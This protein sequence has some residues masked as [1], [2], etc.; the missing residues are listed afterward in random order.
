VQTSE[1]SSRIS[2]L[3]HENLLMLAGLLDCF[4]ASPQRFVLELS[5]LDCTVI[6]CAGVGDTQLRHLAPVPTSMGTLST[7]SYRL[8]KLSGTSGNSGRSLAG[9]G[10]QVTPSTLNIR[11]FDKT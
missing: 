5:K 2:S 8:W 10:D 9:F 6:I 11:D 7:W 4:L 1:L 3:T